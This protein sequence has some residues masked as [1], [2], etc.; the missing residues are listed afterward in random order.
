MKKTVRIIALLFAILL[1]VVSCDSGE[2]A[3]GSATSQSPDSTV[4]ETTQ[5]EL[6]PENAMLSADLT[7][8]TVIRPEN[9]TTS[10]QAAAVKLKGIL[11]S[12]WGATIKVSND[13]DIKKP[14]EYEIL[15]GDTNR[16][17]SATFA[18]TLGGTHYG[19][20]VIGRK[21]VILGASSAGTSKAVDLFLAAIDGKATNK[22]AYLTADES[23]LE[24]EP[25]E[26]RTLRIMSFNVLCANTSGRTG[27]VCNTIAELSP[28]SFG[29]Q[30][31]TKFWIDTL[32]K[33]LGKEYACVG[34]GRD[35]GSSGEHSAVFYKKDKYELLDYGT[36]WLTSTPDTVSKVPE[37]EYRRIAT[38]VILKNKQNGYTYVHINTHLD[39]NSGSI[40]KQQL[41]Y[42]FKALPGTVDG[43]PTFFTGDFNGGIGSTGYNYVVNTKGFKNAAQ[44][45]KKGDKYTHATFETGDVLDY[46]FVKNAKFTVESYH[47]YDAQKLSDHY[48]VYIDVTY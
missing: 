7:K 33:N 45:A 3:D 2:P 37:A 40:R 19:F 30:E 38:Y 9:A 15:V 26:P 23:K 43:L 31:A 32:K 27:P 1:L 11:S 36:K 35:G 14:V 13:G 17:E 22:V 28:D 29:V 6:P 4:P 18:A 47:V 21:V 16:P 46:I 8:Y 5:E 24:E 25:Q 48:P 20:T 41:E 12:R 42:L 39:H 44:L 34:L 10:V